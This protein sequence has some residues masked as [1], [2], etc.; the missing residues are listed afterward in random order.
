M[1]SSCTP[2]RTGVDVEV[3]L[4]ESTGWKVAARE[5]E[6]T[7]GEPFG[8]EVEGARVVLVRDL[9]RVYALA[10]TCSHAGGPLDEGTVRDGT[11]Q[12]PWHHSRFCLDD[13]AVERG[14]AAAPQ[15]TYATRVRDGVIEI[16]RRWPEPPS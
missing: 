16:R 6:L 4:V 2:Q 5:S 7:D 12:C 8:V 11:I 9:G 10:A 1:A 3:P 15:F 14:P 13:G